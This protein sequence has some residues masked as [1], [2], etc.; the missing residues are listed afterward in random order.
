MMV[1]YSGEALNKLSK[2]E[3]IGILM[4]LQNRFKVKNNDIKEKIRNLN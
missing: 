4:L 1:L 3:L 2:S